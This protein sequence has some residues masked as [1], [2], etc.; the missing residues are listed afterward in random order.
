MRTRT[1]TSSP[2]QGAGASEVLK[3]EHD[4]APDAALSTDNQFFERFCTALKAHVGADVYASWFGRLKLHSS[5]KSVIRF[6][7]PTAFL[8]SWIN[9]HYLD[10]LCE[11]ARS[12][13]PQVLKVEVLVRSATRAQRPQVPEEKPK[14]VLPQQT[15]AVRPV[16]RAV[17]DQPLMPEPEGGSARGAAQ[18]PRTVFGSPLDPFFTF[19]SFVEGS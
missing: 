14:P 19:D 7:V 12:E 11:L 9:N 18:G 1:V 15:A 10:L 16:P 4:E 13:R 3:G 6:S 5:S 2:E 17:N 8:K